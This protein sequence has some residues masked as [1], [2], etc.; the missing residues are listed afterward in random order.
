MTQHSWCATL[1]AA[2]PALFDAHGPV[3]SHT[4]LRTDNFG[5]DVYLQSNQEARIVQSESAAVK[6][7]ELSEHTAPG[8]GPRR[9]SETRMSEKRDN[10]SSC[11]FGGAWAA[12][13]R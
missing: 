1:R 5:C 8:D 7:S 4:T 2:L 13:R 3:V 9:L 6:L 12:H 10:R 11:W